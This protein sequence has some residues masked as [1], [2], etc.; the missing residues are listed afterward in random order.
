MFGSRVGGVGRAA[1]AAGVWPVGAGGFCAMIELTE[2]SKPR[3]TK[4]LSLV[5]MGQALELELRRM[6]TESALGRKGEVLRRLGEAR[7]S[8]M[9]PRS[10]NR[11]AGVRIRGP[12]AYSRRAR[13]YVHLL[14]AAGV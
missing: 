12:E 1:G 5:R 10:R 6:I 7:V 2:T 9:R 11:D 3:Q 14:Q 13:R 4:T 8:R